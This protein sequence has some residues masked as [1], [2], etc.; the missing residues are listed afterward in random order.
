M[1]AVLGDFI[2]DCVQNSVEAGAKRIEIKIL[3][4]PRFIG[5]TIKDDGC[6]MDE[7]QLVSALDPF[8]TNGK[9]HV[10]RKVG[11]GLP[12]L[13]QAMDL[14]G[15]QF[16][17]ESKKGQGTELVFGYDPKAVDA[18]PIGK[19]EEAF[20]QILLFAGNHELVINRIY[21]SDEGK[22][23]EYEIVKS[24]LLEVLGNLE[25]AESLILARDFLR[26]QEDF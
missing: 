1:H 20:L 18:S 26:S 8:Y 17:I 16:R 19:L 9:K 21:K 14:A 4:E 13:K 2:V 7:G 3:Q 15:G 6:G 23:E 12:F 24:E 10:H 25:Q 5:I 11:L 22:T